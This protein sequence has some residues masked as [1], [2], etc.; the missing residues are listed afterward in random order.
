MKDKWMNIGFDSD[1]LLPYLEPSA[2]L[3][4]PARIRKYI[5]YLVLHVH[6]SQLRKR[7]IYSLQFVNLYHLN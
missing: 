5:V 3:N 1:E 4:D 7:V 6:L 2:D